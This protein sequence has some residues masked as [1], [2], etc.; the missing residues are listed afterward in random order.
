MA[1]NQ[2]DL[3]TSPN[4]G[5]GT[6]LRTGGG[7]IN[8]I[9]TEMWD[10]VSGGIAYLAGSVGINTN[11]LFTFLVV[12]T[13]ATNDGIAIEGAAGINR[14]LLFTTGELT[15]WQV[16][17]NSV[18]ESGSNAGSNFVISRYSDAGSFIDTALV[19]DRD[20]GQIDMKA[21][22]S[23]TTAS[24][25]NMFIASN[26]SLQRSTSSEKLKKDIEP[27]TTE[28]SNN[29]YKIAKESA[30][31]FKSLCKGDNKDWTYYG[32]S[33]EKLA[34]I[35]PRLVH[36]GYWPEDYEILTR[37]I[38]V[39]EIIKGKKVKVTKQEQYKALKK[40]A[41]MTPVGVQYSRIVP[42]MLVEMDKMND[43]LNDLEKRLVALEK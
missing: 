6:N 16:Y 35:E 27:I 3:G 23:E 20:T 21:I 9:I 14:A 43:K 36:W 18:A 4:D 7:Y 31:F 13:T 42:L 37:D 12:K 11:S 34:L 22:F 19:I 17:N 1:L 30:I 29:I 24:A 5:T 26:G 39:E 41:E 33:A 10:T 25:E 2:I 40:D 8:A 28:Y 15:R 38:E 32:I